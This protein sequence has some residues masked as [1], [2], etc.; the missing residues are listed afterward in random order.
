MTKKALITGIT[1]QDGSYLA[2]LLLE[3]KYEVHGI[4]RRVAIENQK[5]RYSR[6]KHLLGQIFIH[7]GDITDYSTMHD[8]ITDVQPNELYHLAAQSDVAESFRDRKGTYR[9]NIEGTDNVLTILEKRAPQCRFYFAATSEMFGDQLCPPNGFDENDKFRPRSPYGWT[10]V[11]G[12]HMT[13][14]TRETGK[15]FA[16]S[17]IL[18][19]HESPRRGLEFVTQKI[20]NY[21]V[22]MWAKSATFLAEPLQMG[23]LNS[24]RDWGYAPEYVK[25]MW[26]MLQQSNPDDFVVATGQM[27]T[28]REFVEKTFSYLGV[29]LQWR[30]SGI[31]EKGYDSENDNLLVEV[32]P[33]F[34][35]STDVTHLRGNAAKARKLLDWQPATDADSLIKIMADAEMEKY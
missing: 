15:C 14:T 2:E 12:Y 33:A 22:G 1:G 6:I 10:K 4:V 5:H 11:M 9:I 23:N 21:V 8:I 34:F 31:N 16:C 30:G 18:F 26:L 27:N 28:I 19:N 32:N 24:Q 29:K 17:G 13:R 25:A 20:V 3:K 35:R 7:S